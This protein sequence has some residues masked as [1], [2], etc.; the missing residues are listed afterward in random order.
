MIEFKLQLEPETMTWLRM[1]ARRRKMST[2]VLMRE[3]IR[4]YRQ[5][6][7]QAGGLGPRPGERMDRVPH[8]G[9]RPVGPGRPTGS[10]PVESLEDAWKHIS[11]PIVPEEEPPPG[12]LGRGEAD[13]AQEGGEE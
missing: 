9:G 11:R 7:G 10:R 8:G 1:E 6:Q 2:Q 13:S 4:T 3:V 5:A 12:P